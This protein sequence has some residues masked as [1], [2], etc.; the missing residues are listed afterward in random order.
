MSL[1]PGKLA[2]TQKPVDYAVAVSSSSAIVGCLPI[3]TWEDLSLT[4]H[5]Q[6]VPHTRNPWSK[7]TWTKSPPIS[8]MRGQNVLIT[9]I[10]T[11]EENYLLMWYVIHMLKKSFYKNYMY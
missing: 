7:N 5:R 8:G 1:L 9:K 10:S 11:N 6:N 3:T 2:V 4:E